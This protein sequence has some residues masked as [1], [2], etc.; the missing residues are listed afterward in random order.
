ME[1]SSASIGSIVPEA[2]HALC[3][4]ARREIDA[5][6]LPSCQLALAIDGEL[7]HAQT[8]GA[9]P[10]G[11]ATRYAIFSATKAVV[12]AA[13]WQLLAEGELALADP[14][15]SHIPEF[16]ANGKGAV[17]VEQVLL[18]T[19]GFPRAPLG[20]PDWSTRAGRLAAF[21]RWRLSSEP[22]TRFEYHA[23][24]AHWVRAELLERT[25][26]VDF[27]ESV[28]RRVLDPLGL[29]RLRLGVPVAE[30]GDIAK[31]ALVGEP[32]TREEW[33]EALG[34]PGFERG[35]VTDEAL[36]SFGRPD[37]LAVGVPGAGAV[38]DASDLALF[39]QA[40][41]HD[42]AKLWDPGIL[43]DAVG[44]VRN[45]F[46]DLQTGVAANRA[47][48]VVVAGADGSPAR[49]GFGHR[50]GPRAFGHNGAG[51]QIAF[52][53]PDSGLSFAYLTNGLDRH[54]LRQWRRGTGIASRA[55][56]CVR[57]RG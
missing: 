35:E 21:A 13:I 51:G 38:S 16:A 11:E 34:V 40:L 42:P 57:T 47:L 44:K 9:A 22:G 6:L 7:V 8:F 19:A 4:R 52:A 46:P 48:G 23:S 5:G 26:G 28:H 24:S 53:D 41:L 29:R 20:P 45:T 10:A 2:V 32:P 18:H 36:D 17:T 31:V 33:E 54:W 1:R 50:V 56:V 25:D 43:G 55:A 15:A 27:R 49:R 39:Y 14:V 37:V 30:Q 12:A 3:E